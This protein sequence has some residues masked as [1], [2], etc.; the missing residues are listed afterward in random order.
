MIAAPGP[1][2]P[3]DDLADLPTGQADGPLACE[4][5]DQA[6]GT[7]QGQAATCARRRDPPGP[8]HQPVESPV[9]LRREPFLP[10][11]PKARELLPGRPEGG[12][13]PI[14][15]GPRSLGSRGRYPLAACGREPGGKPSRSAR[16]ASRSPQCGGVPGRMCPARPGRHPARPGPSPVPSGAGVAGPSR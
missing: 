1:G 13:N 5:L 16:A 12:E 8:Q 10:V 15:I 3:I 6:G 11:T 14:P 7:L 4:D 2:V 9:A